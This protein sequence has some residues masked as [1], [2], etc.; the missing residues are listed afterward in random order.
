MLGNN[1][2]LTEVQW[3]EIQ[4]HEFRRRLVGRKGIQ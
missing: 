4:K 1:T 3:S 2:K